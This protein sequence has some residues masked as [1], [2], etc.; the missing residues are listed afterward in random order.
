[1]PV[2]INECL[3]CLKKGWMDG[4]TDG[5]MN[6]WVDGQMEGLTDGASENVKECLLQSDLF[7][8]L[9]FPLG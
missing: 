4:W 6:R 7:G 9:P 5:W 3:L 8:T 2:L 1:M